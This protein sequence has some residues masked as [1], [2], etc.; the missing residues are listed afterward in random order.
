MAELRELA[1]EYEVP[2]ASETE[3][4]SVGEG[5]FGGDVGTLGLRGC[6]G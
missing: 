2:W 4:A 5:T 1:Q 6:T 3:E